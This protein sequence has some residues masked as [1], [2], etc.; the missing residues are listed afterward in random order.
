MNTNEGGNYLTLN[1]CFVYVINLHIDTFFSIR[2][3]VTDCM[4]LV[5][6]FYESSGGPFSCET[7]SEIS[8]EISHQVGLCGLPYLKIQVNIHLKFH[9]KIQVNFHLK[10]HLKMALQSFRRHLMLIITEK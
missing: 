4:N 7:S 5:T 2:S 1:T 6:H 9:L 8:L 3:T 10:F